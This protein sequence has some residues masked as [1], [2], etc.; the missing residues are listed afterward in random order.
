M[1]MSFIYKTKWNSIKIVYNIMGWINL[2]DLSYKENNR[3]E[4]ILDRKILEPR[5]TKTNH[6]LIWSNLNE[7]NWILP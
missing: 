2:N 5:Q 4:K 6:Q 1:S 7:I 3:F